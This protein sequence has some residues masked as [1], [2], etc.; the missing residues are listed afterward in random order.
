M[1]QFV[2]AGHETSAGSLTWTTYAL[3]MNPS[4]QDRLRK[5]ILSA[6]RAGNGEIDYAAIESMHFLNNVL[7]ESIRL[8]SPSL[9]LPREAAEDMVIG[10]VHIPKGT[11]VTMVP[12]M[13]Q[14]N[15]LIWGEDAEVF[16]PDRWDNWTTD[17]GS[18]YAISAFSGG[19]RVC[20]GRSFAY[21]EMK[22]IL[23]ELL[24]KFI[25]EPVDRRPTLLN[26]AVTLKPNGGLKVNVLRAV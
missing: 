24:S 6:T 13:V 1:L 19:P 18:P 4:I 9:T 26:P 25:F 10:G 23:V 20:V 11:T 14:I 12:A 3:A 15:P 21:L 5:E 16:N 2:I 22:A 17:S 7:R 8:Y